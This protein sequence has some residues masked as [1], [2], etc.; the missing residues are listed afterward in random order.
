MRERRRP[1]GR[2]WTEFIGGGGGYLSVYLSD[3]RATYPVRHITLRRNNKSDPNLETGTYGLFSTCGLSMRGKLV[4]EGRSHLFFVTTHGRRPRAL[5]GYYE[6]GWYA[7]S[8][9]G[10]RQGDLALAARRMRF[11]EPIPLDSLPGTTGEVCARRF[12]LCRPLPPDVCTDLLDLLHRSDDL[13]GA[14][15]AEI[16]RLERWAHEQ[17]GFSYPSWRRETGFT[18]A[19]GVAY[20]GAVPQPPDR[21]PA[22][23]WR[24]RSCGEVSDSH[25]CLKACPDCGAMGTLEP[26]PEP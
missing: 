5:A 3:P 8:I 24:C 21:R 26:V 18:P 1:P 11:V 15:L 19:D 25:A 20:L 16:G 13:T 2:D 17:T 12:R 10:A 22:K 6:V 4:R 7:E 9:L 23:R 14:Y